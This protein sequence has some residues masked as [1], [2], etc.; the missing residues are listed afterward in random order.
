MYSLL[1]SSSGFLLRRHVVPPFDFGR[2]A[3]LPFLAGVAVVALADCGVLEGRAG[4]LDGGVVVEEVAPR[5]VAA[6]GH[7][8]EFGRLEGI[9]G[10][11]ADEGDVHA[12]AAV[13]AGAGEADENAEFRGGLGFCV[14]CG[15]DRRSWRE[16]KGACV[17]GGRQAVLDEDVPIVGLGRHSRR[18]GYS[19]SLSGSRGATMD[20]I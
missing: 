5:L 14:N 8:Q 4:E 12:E 17:L 19:R 1:D 20:H 18:S 9:H 15:R 16:G 10:Y 2:E 7:A 3:L 11:A 6:L 13:D